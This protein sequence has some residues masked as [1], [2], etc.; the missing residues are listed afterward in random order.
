MASTRFGPLE[1]GGP[2]EMFR[3]RIRLRYRLGGNERFLSHH[4]MMR[5]WDRALRRSG[6]PLRMTEGFNVRPRMSFALARGVGIASESE[7]LEFEL[8]DWVDPDTV[9]DRLAGALP[10]GIAIRELKVVPPDFRAI[11]TETVYRVDLPEPPPPD[12]ERRIE[13]FLA[14]DEAV[15][16]RGGEK[17]PRRVDIRPMIRSVSFRGEGLEMVTACRDS[18]A[19]RP[20]EVLAELGLTQDVI[21]RSLVVRTESRLRDERN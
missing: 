14:R 3:E 21:A 17:R 16:E 4:D 12:L 1:I 6:L 15:V 2:R 13:D 18:G 9:Y 7:W 11:V 10:S 5:L 20:Q 8:A 19:A